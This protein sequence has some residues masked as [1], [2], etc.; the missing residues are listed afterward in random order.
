MIMGLFNRRRGGKRRQLPAPARPLRLEQLEERCV[1]SYTIGDLGTL[2][3]PPSAAYAM[4]ADASII[5]GAADT[6]NNPG[7]DPH[8]FKYDT[9]MHGLGTLG[10]TTSKALAVDNNATP[11]VAGDSQILIGTT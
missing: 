8:A 5:V 1:L 9:S 7:G 11:D 3:G 2:G 4:N 6:D 10:G